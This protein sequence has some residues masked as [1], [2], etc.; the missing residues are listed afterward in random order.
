MERTSLS[1]IKLFLAH[2]SAIDRGLPGNRGS[3]F[4]TGAFP[5][6]KAGGTLARRTAAR[7]NDCGRGGRFEETEQLVAS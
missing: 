6:R 4:C 7:Y 1:T 5:K 2:S 3:L